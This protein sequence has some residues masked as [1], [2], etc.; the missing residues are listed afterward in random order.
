MKL[1]ET[2]NNKKNQKK[3][4]KQFKTLKMSVII[5]KMI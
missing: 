3:K 2:K 4:N 5:L 1:I